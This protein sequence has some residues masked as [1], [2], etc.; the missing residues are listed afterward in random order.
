MLLGGN[1]KVTIFWC[2]N[3][4][5]NTV[6]TG[7][8]GQKNQKRNKKSLTGAAWR[9][10]TRSRRCGTECLAEPGRAERPGTAGRKSFLK[11]AEESG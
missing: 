1:S 9:C 10:I 7:S 11:K 4:S 3:R 5:E 2:S 8:V 6:E